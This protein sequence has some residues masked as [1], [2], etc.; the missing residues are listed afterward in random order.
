VSKHYATTAFTD[1]VRAVQ[2]D[3][4]S[5]AF[6]DRKR[7]IGRATP[8]ADPLTEA[9]KD[10]L[11]ERVDFYVASVGET[12][13][14][15]VQYRG[16]PAGFVR[17]LDDNTIAW[18]DF[19]GN[20]QYITTGNVS[21]DDRIAIIAVDYV[22]QRRLKIFGRVRVVTVED[23]PDLVASLADSA[24][25]AVPERAVIVHVEAYDWNCPQHITRRFTAVELE[26]ILA[27]MREQL[28]TL[29]AENA[30]LRE[31]LR[32]ST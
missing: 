22:H 14:P 12:G 13:W 20:L 19:R 11:G 7:A 31:E 1:G 23:D 28:A 10:Y 8:G 3:H 17:V 5:R 27:P 15:Y 9:E 29:Q 26:P 4:G 6:Y 21:G 2:E 25:E 30:R 32:A 18:A 24:Y 16:G